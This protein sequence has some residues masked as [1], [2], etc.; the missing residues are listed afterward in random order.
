MRSLE[1][2]RKLLEARFARFRR[3]VRPG[4]REGCHAGTAFESLN[5]L[6]QEEVQ[7][8]LQ[9]LQDR[10]ELG[11]AAFEFHV[12]PGGG[13]ALQLGLSQLMGQAGKGRIFT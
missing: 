11:A 9:K 2:S 3:Y 13:V 7:A 6:K 4:V 8:Q 1:T 5:E 12:D 10:P